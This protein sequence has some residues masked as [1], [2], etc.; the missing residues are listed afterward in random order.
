ERR[1]CRRRCESAES[2]PPRKKRRFQSAW[3]WEASR[4]VRA[5]AA[6]RSLLP[7][8]RPDRRK[9]VGDSHLPPALL[10]LLPVLESPLAV[11]RRGPGPLVV[12][13]QPLFSRLL[14]IPHSQILLAS[15]LDPRCLPRERRASPGA[16]PLRRRTSR[17]QGEAR[18]VSA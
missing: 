1:S 18:G 3:P 14:L 13:A 11:D 16:G 12:L 15:F 5:S 7:L 4:Q 2:A 10:L 9:R 8:R 6:A 17:S